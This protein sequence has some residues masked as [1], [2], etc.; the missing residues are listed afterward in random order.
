MKMLKSIIRFLTV[1]AVAAVIGTTLYLTMH[2]VIQPIFNR[3]APN[4]REEATYSTVPK[5]IEIPEGRELI[6]ES[7]SVAKNGI[8]F[9]VMT[10]LVVGIQNI[11]PKLLRPYKSRKKERP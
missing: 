7:F 8:V 4:P 5:P 10:I 3:T 6:R 1:L 11:S 9:V 2:L